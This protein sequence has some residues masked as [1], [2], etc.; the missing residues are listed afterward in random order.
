MARLDQDSVVVCSLSHSYVVDIGSRSAHRLDRF[1]G[2]MLR[3]PGRG[4]KRLHV[5]ISARAQTLAD[6][7]CSQASYN[8][9]SQTVRL[10]ANVFNRSSSRNQL[11]AA[12]ACV[13]TGVFV[14]L[15]PT[16]RLITRPVYDLP[17]D[18]PPHV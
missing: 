1:G 10:S 6:V 8:A 5:S 16:V 18:P 3:H 14:S 9:I 2:R 7:L 4:N 17:H 13:A 12:T 11:H 15:Y